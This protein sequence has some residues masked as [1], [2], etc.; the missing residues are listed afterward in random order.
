MRRS[1]LLLLVVF[2]LLLTACAPGTEPAIAAPTFTVLESGTGF[3][4]VDP[5]GIG[6]GAAVFDIHL[7]AHNPNRIGLSLASLDGDFYLGDRRA[8]T[9]TFRHGIELPARGS[10]DLTMEVRVPL[11]QAPALLQTVAG[12]LTGAATSYRVD[13]TVGVRVFG[14]VQRFPRTTLAQGSVRWSPKWAAPEIRLASSGPTLH[15]DSLTSATLD[16]QATLHN[17][18]RLGYVVQAPA[19]RLAL[20]G[21]DVATLQ[22]DRI[23]APAGATVPIDLRFRFN[24]LQVGPA[25][26]TQVSAVASGAGSLDFRVSG[27]LSLQAPGLASHQVDAT[28]LLTG[29][30]R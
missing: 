2:P 9:T 26:A 1:W 15:I 30:L 12:L 10:S 11:A 21:A 17:P 29:T 19:V 8:A 14:A 16:I 5:P 23:I 6:E 13:A 20:G 27:P 7:R 22:L 25:L 4:Y 18:S 28:A 24:P 3:Q